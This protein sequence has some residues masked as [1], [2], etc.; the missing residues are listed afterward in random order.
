MTSDLGLIPA[1]DLPPS[2]TAEPRKKLRLWPIVVLIGIFWTYDLVLD[3]LEV[4]MFARFM[5]M[6]A[7]TGLLVLLFSVWW[8]ANRRV[9]GKDRLL[10]LAAAVGGG[11][12]SG[13]LSSKVGWIAWLLMSLP[14]VVTTWT[15][16]L[17]VTRN[18]SDP[19]RRRSVLVTLLLTWSA[20]L[21]LR[22]EGLT[23]D[24]HTVLRWRWSPT[25][26][27]LYRAERE[28]RKAEGTS[29]ASTELI[30][31]PGDWPGF[32]GPQRDGVVRGLTID[33][34]WKA[35]PPRPLWRQRVGPGWSSMIIVGDRLFT[36]EQRGTAEAVVCLDAKNGHEVWSHEDAGRFS[37]DQS[38]AGPRATPTFA[39]G[40][41]YTLGATG[42]LNCFDAA[43]GERKW[44]RNLVDEA[45]AKLPI[46]GFSS[47]PLLVQ[48]LVIVFAEGKSGKTLLAYRASSG[49]LAWSTDAGEASYSSP[50]LASLAGAEQILFLGA[51]G[52][53]GIDPASGKVLWKHGLPSSGM[54]RSLQPHPFGPGQVLLAGEKEGVQLVDVKHDGESW[55]AS[56][57]W[58][59]RALKPTFND[60]VVHDG[61]IYGFDGNIFCCVDAQTGA[62]RWKD[63]RY[64]NGQVLLLAD[65]ALLLVVSEEGKVILLKANPESHEELGRFEA[66]TGKTWNHPAIAQGRLYVRNGEEIACYPLANRSH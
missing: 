14:W 42:I 63:G 3:R 24:G 62:R 56:R 38:G 65:Q 25:A 23:G 10:C 64:G 13:F 44:S 50:H 26:E 2:T 19:T 46:W 39:E 11:I 47:S 57:H 4:G 58:G 33:T 61:A 59:T 31:Q 37:D 32:R 12:L 34:D 17:L 15:A 53:L 54:M 27:E 16:A 43:T 35:S 20:F 29:I 7:S 1:Q 41:L 28:Q 48:D 8:L 52:L 18:A 51:Q 55:T 5:A 36:Q 40:R 60:F 9:A 22:S 49:E 21:L 66:I 45:D 6:L 30:V